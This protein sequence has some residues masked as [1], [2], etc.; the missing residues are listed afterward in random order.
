MLVSCLFYM[1]LGMTFTS[2]ISASLFVYRRY[3]FIS[4]MVTDWTLSFTIYRYLFVSLLVLGLMLDF[5]AW[6]LPILTLLASSLCHPITWL[7]EVNE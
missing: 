7:Y 3:T 2:W 4:N 5:G 1:F 6:I